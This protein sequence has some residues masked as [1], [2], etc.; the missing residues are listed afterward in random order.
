MVKKAFKLAEEDPFELSQIFTPLIT[1][2][3]HLRVKSLANMDGITNNTTSRWCIPEG[4]P[5]FP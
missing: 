5:D 2:D 1:A 3:E 4:Q